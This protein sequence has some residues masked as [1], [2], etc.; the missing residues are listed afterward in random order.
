[1]E[2]GVRALSDSCNMS[3]QAMVTT[4]LHLSD[5]HYGN[6][7]IPWALTRR[8]GF[9]KRPSEEITMGLRTV[10]R[11]LKPDFTVISGDFVN[12][13]RPGCFSEAAVYL[14]NLLVNAG[15]D[16]HGSVLIVPGNHDVGFLGK[17][18]DESVRL[19]R[20]RR[21]VEQFYQ[22]VNPDD[23]TTRFVCRS[24]RHRLLFLALD[25]TLKTLEPRAEGEIGNRQMA[26]AK[27][28]LEE[29]RRQMGVE[30]DRYIKIAIM[31]HHC[32]AITGENVSAERNMQLLDAG[33]I[34]TLLRENGFDVV[35]HGHKHVPH[36]SPD[37]RGDG[38]VLTIV[39]AG[40]ALAPYP[41]QQGVYGNNFNLIR[42]DDA[43]LEVAITRYHARSDG[44]FEP[45]VGPIKHPLGRP[46][47]EGYK[48]RKLRRVLHIARNGDT[49]AVVERTDMLVVGSNRIK[50][51]PLRF[52]TTLADAEISGFK[53]VKS[54]GA[55]VEWEIETAK[56]YSGFIFFPTER[57]ASDGGISLVHSY[58]TKKGMLMS[59]AAKSR[60]L[61]NPTGSFEQ[62]VTSVASDVEECVVEL[63]FPA[64]Y[65][66]SPKVIIEHNGVELDESIFLNKYRLAHDN[67]N[68]D[69]TLLMANPPVRYGIIL[70][71]ELPRDWLEEE[72]DFRTQPA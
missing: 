12:K 16:I 55:T 19:R 5:I 32:A 14:R 64:G 59:L 41:D 37:H 42:I 29:S 24:D 56:M 46:P 9:T 53:F 35:L 33:G 27:Q 51:L 7:F 30:F 2:S 13:A 21:F 43:A 34:M 20:Y 6:D 52:S 58:K 26:W 67:I 71:W 57:T 69:W 25:T 61:A 22:D 65:A 60:R 17:K 38:G 3:F 50:K 15:V 36:V 40:T 1:M 63:H 62:I 66:V 39:G 28:Q 10:I 31:H 49:E 4:I 8:R 54:S 45:T 44:S 18:P 70:R 11:Q 47:T 68:N 72:V 48:S 23:R